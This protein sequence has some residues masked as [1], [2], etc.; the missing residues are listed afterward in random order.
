MVFSSF[1][2]VF[3]L[4]VSFVAISS[5]SG[6]VVK[7]DITWNGNW[8]FACD[9]YGN[10]LTNAQIRG[11]DCGGRCAQT[12]GCTHFTWT[13]YN[14]GT[15]WMKQGPV[16]KSNAR[17]T[18]DQSMVCGINGDSGPHHLEELQEEL[19]DIGIAVNQVAVGLAK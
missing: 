5:L 1:I 10:D 19:H 17:F 4:V 6:H 3:V 14:G 2:S 9:F 7:R 8:A 18:N 13:T 15:C 12:A 16:S 11:E